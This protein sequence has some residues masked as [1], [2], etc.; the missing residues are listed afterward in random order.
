MAETD[1]VHNMETK[2]DPYLAEYKKLVGKVCVDVVCDTEGVDG[3]PLYGLV[4]KSGI[5]DRKPSVAW[6]YRDE[7][8][9]GAGFLNIIDVDLD[10]K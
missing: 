1:I 9:N 2:K 6:V 5:K 7:E 10:A 8:G 4:F 3:E